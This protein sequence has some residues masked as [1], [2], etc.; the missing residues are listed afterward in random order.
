[1]RRYT[2]SSKL[3]SLGSF[4]LVLVL[5]LFA[6]GVG[7]EEDAAESRAE[8]PVG[9]LFTFRHNAM[10]TVFEIQFYPPSPNMLREDVQ[11]IAEEV[12]AYIDALESRISNWQEES[13]ISRVNREAYEKPVV[14]SADIMALLEFSQDMH[15]KTDGIFD[16]TVGPLLEL[17]GFYRK[18]GHLPNAEELQTALDRVG[19]Q[20][21]EIDVEED[22]VRLLKPGMHID[23]GGIGKGYAVDMGIR[24]LE[25]HGVTRALFHSGT[26][27]AYALGAPPGREGW[28]VRLERAYTLGETHVEEVTIRDESFSTSSG[29]EKFFE[30]GG[31]RYGHIFDPRTGMPAEPV[32]LTSM[33]TG[34]TGTLTDALATAF[35]VMGP[36]EVAAYVERNPEVG[37]VLLVRDEDGEVRAKRY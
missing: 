23:F 13:L 37:A 2:H 12:F 26:S 27:S 36:E 32:V 11:P 35:Y 31:R 21:V 30:L 3:I 34:P 24:I 10:A 9:Q 5:V 14:V 8:A 19:M 17:W 20:Y 25:R 18:A 29:F 22:T 1:M 28:T 15:E 7:A 4:A 6:R 16:V 33:V